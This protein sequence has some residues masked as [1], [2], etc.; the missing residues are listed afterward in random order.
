MVPYTFK[1]KLINLT[2]HPFNLYKDEGD[3]KPA[4]SLQACQEP[5]R[6]EEKSSVERTIEVDGVKIPVYKKRVSEVQGMPEPQADVRYIVPR[7]VAQKVKQTQ[8]HRN[9][10]LVP[11]DLVRDEEG[12]IIGCRSLAKL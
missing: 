6:I 2:P 1:K 12:K 8:F 3:S 4:L 5:P 11:N 9:D 7:I 10:L